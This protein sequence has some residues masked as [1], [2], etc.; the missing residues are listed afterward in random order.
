MP[1]LTERC[2][3]RIIIPK[4]LDPTQHRHRHLSERGL[5]T[6]FASP[7]VPTSS[8]PAKGRGLGRVMRH[9]SLLSVDRPGPAQAVPQ[10]AP[11]HDPSVSRGSRG[12]ACVPSCRPS[13]S[14]GRPAPRVWV[15]RGEEEDHLV[16][17]RVVQGKREEEGP[18]PGEGESARASPPLVLLH[19]CAPYPR[20][21]QNQ[22][23][24]PQSPPFP[25]EEV[26]SWW[27]SP[28]Q[29]QGVPV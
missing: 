5:D 19:W 2:F 3:I 22:A 23:H 13:R 16:G 4:P 26:R 29:G 11:R 25:L 27:R 28:A 24:H 18:R 17:L 7:G 9:S 20:G 14:R 12:V 15:V 1:L 8:W 10:P 6:S 21:T